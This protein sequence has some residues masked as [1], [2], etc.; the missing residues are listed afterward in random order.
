M[1]EDLENMLPEVLEPPTSIQ[2]KFSKNLPT[3]PLKRL[4]LRE[5]SVEEVKYIYIFFFNFN[6]HICCA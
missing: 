6:L 5:V 4:A 1:M 2:G 3:P